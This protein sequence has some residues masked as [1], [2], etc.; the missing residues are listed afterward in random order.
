MAGMFEVGVIGFNNGGGLTR[1]TRTVSDR[2]VAAPFALPMDDLR[3][4]H[5]HRRDRVSVRGVVCG[6]RRRPEFNCR[7]VRAVGGRSLL[8]PS[9]HIGRRPHPGVFRFPGRGYQNV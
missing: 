6:L 3:S 5:I 9:S 1:I 8:V 2:I 7:C 4:G